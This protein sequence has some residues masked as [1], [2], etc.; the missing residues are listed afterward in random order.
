MTAI[1][2]KYQT[3]MVPLPTSYSL[4]NSSL[5]SNRS[6]IS[7]QDVLIGEQWIVLAKIGEG[8][9]G[10]VFEGKK[11]DDRSHYLL[12]CLFYR[13]HIVKDIDTG[14]HYAVKREPWSGHPSQIKHE[15]ILYDILAAGRKA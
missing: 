4:T 11:R 14:R 10:E 13:S 1:N 5:E 2:N 6:N 9:F 8:S 3:Q 7:N 15:S 12:R